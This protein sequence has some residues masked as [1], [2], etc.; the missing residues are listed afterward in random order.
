[1]GISPQIKEK[2]M[3]PGKDFAIRRFFSLVVLCLAASGAALAQTQPP[4]NPAPADQ[5]QTIQA[6]LNEVRQLR[7]AIERMSLS[8]YRAQIAVERLRLQQERVERLTQDLDAVRDQI[9]DEDLQEPLM[10]ELIEGMETKERA[11]TGDEME[12]KMLKAQ[13]EQRGQRMKQLRERETQLMAQ[14]DV[15]RANLSDII[16]RLDVLERELESPSPAGEPQSSGR[17]P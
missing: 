1:M 3:S 6:L 5:G 17:R 9:R 14:L 13:I 8:A 4:P 11:G 12:L 2:A 7:L 16:Y 10:K 15:E